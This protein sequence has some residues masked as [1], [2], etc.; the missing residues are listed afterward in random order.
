MVYSRGAKD[1]YDR[2]ANVT[3]DKGWSWSSMLPYFLKVSGRV[4]HNL[5]PTDHTIQLE[6]FTNSPNV[7]DPSDKYIPALH[8]TKGPLGVGL[9]QVSLPL[10]SLL[11]EAQQDLSSEFPF[12][13]DVNSGDMIGFSKYS[14]VLHDLT[15]YT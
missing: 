4:G 3:G 12:N 15:R 2:W 11:L 14:S 6:N 10:D 5:A 13:H 9:P 8:N 7:Q 1:D